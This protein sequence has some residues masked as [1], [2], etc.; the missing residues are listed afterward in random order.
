MCMTWLGKEY[1]INDIKS[2]AQLDIEYDQNSQVNTMT[3]LDIECDRVKHRV[4][5]IV[6]L[7]V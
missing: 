1:D 3:Q 6:R 5:Y 2:V 7:G 4:Q